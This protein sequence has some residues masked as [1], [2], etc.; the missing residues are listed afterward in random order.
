MNEKYI[1]NTLLEEVSIKK[2]KTVVTKGTKQWI[3]G[4][5]MI[6]NQEIENKQNKINIESKEMEITNDYP[7]SKASTPISPSSQ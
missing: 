2:S 3:T 7:S 4:N 5:G 6:K 1:L